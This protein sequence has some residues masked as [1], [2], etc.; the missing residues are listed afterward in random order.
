MILRPSFPLLSARSSSTPSRPLRLTAHQPIVVTSPSLPRF[1]PATMT[2]SEEVVDTNPAIKQLVATVFE[3]PAPVLLASQRAIFL[4]RRRL[5]A[6]L[7]ADTAISSQDRF[8]G[9]VLSEMSMALAIGDQPS[10]VPFTFFPYSWRRTN[11]NLQ[12][13]PR[14]KR[15]VIQ[16]RRYATTYLAR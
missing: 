14:I 8:R 2:R 12:Q 16:R 3:W 9:S 11:I 1:L 13:I 10:S 5:M 6:T 7:L 15:Q 4:A